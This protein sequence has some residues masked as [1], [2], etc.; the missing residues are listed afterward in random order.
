[1]VKPASDPVRRA[2]FVLVP[3]GLTL[4]LWIASAQ[5]SR[6][7]DDAALRNAGKAGGDWLSYGVTQ[8]ET[9]YSPLNQINTSNVS[10]L[11]LAWSYDSGPGGGNQEGT[12][13]EW[14][15]TLYGMTNW[16]VVF[17]LDVRTGKE[18]WRWDPE[19]NQTAVRPKVCCG[20][21]HRGIAMYQGKIIAP[22][23]D[24]RLVALNAETGKPVCV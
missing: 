6:R 17:A 22:V 19:V 2:V 15:G 4:A 12:P 5:E 24:G 8:G 9:R 1:M 13:L 11:G 3:F 16:S 21:V 23:I 10:R 18:R 7:V 14:N 20:I